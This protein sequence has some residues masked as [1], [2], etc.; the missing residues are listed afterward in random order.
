MPRRSHGTRSVSRRGPKNNL[1]SVVLQDELS[2]GGGG[3]LNSNIVQG[4]DWER[5]SGSSE[6]STLMTIRGWLSV[7]SRPTAGVANSAGSLHAYIGVFDEDET[8]PGADLASTYGDEDILWT[9]GYSYGA[10]G[11]MADVDQAFNVIF[12]VKAQ[13][14]VRNGQKVVLSLQSGLTT[15]VQVSGVQRALLRLGGN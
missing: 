4:S 11:D 1:W 15:A 2:L 10:A 7:Q 14:K 5:A 6:R 8:P 9:G 13:R 12:E 3:A